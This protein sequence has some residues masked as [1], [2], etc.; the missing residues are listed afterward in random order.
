[1]K[2]AMKSREKR[3]NEMLATQKG[4]AFASLRPDH[5]DLTLTSDR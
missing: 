4:F 3:K 1:M 2:R 5:L